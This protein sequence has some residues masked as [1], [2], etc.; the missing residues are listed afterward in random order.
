MHAPNLCYYCML[1][2]YAP[3]VC[4]YNL[5]LQYAATQHT[6]SRIMLRYCTIAAYSSSIAGSEAQGRRLLRIQ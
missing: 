6:H 5:V 4:S 3:T 1:L 2:L